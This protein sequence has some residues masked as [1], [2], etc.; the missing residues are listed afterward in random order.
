MTCPFL[1]EA[2]VQ[3]CQTAAFRKLIPLA[4][5]GRA[6]EKCASEAHASCPVFRLQHHEADAGACPFLRES[7]MQYCG[8]APV[9]R[10]VPYSESLLSRC[11]NDGFRYC[12]AYLQLAHPEVSTAEE[13]HIAA[14]DW[15]RYSANHMW[16]D[17]TEDGSCHVG[18][19][20]FLSRSLGRV[21]A[22]S[23]VWERGRHRPAAVL[24]AGGI[25]VEVVFPNAML[26][27]GCNR[28]LRADPS[29]LSTDPY[30]A[31]WLFEGTPVEGTL[32]HLLAG[33]E[34]PVVDGRG[35]AAHERV[36]AIVD[37]GNGAGRSCSAGFYVRRRIV[38]RRSGGATQPQPGPG[39]GARIFLALR[40]WKKDFR[41][42]NR[43]A[44][45]A[46]VLAALGAGWAG[47]PRAIYRSRPQPVDFS[48]KVHADKAGA[49]CEDCHDFRD[50]GS[51]AGLPTLDKCAGCHARA[52]GNHGGGE[53]LHRRL[54]DARTRSRTGWLTRGSR[55]MCPSR[56]SRT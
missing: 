8:A 39:A 41:M 54:R 30:T 20:A 9:A 52:H 33:A 19:D 24:T 38:R 16:L 31:G 49:K 56:T 47:F 48:H 5:A 2:A 13:D 6:D 4:A 32:D 22:V 27:A 46:G 12:E 10:F 51:F 15:L 40:E 45:L 44:F 3:Y 34:A 43:V 35:A 26:I 29:K 50:D 37:R 25:E 11:G 21:E 55:K 18:I 23:Y 28:Y 42:R 17:A 36:P 53:E 7:L 14:P 1:R